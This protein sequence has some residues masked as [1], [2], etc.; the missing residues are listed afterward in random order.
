MTETNACAGVGA[1]S[2]FGWREFLERWSKE[3]AGAQDP[4]EDGRDG[5]E[6]AVRDRWLGFAPA[7][8]ERLA[9]C[10]ARL[11]H[12]LPPSYRSFLEVT[13]GWRHAG[14]FVY[15][16]ADTEQVHWHEDESGIGEM[17]REYLDEDAS[18][19]EIQEAAIWGRSLQLDVESDATSV[20]MDPEDVDEHGEWAVFTWAPWKA[21]PPERFASFWE[22]MQDAYREFH[23][24]SAGRDGE[25]AF[26]NATTE[27]LDAGVEEARQAALAGEYERATAAFAEAM[28]FGRPRATALRAQLEHLSGHY[29]SSSLRTL[30]SDPLYAPEVLPVIA[31]TYR[32]GPGDTAWIRHDVRPVLRPAAEEAA[33][34]AQARTFRYEPE[35]PFGAAVESAREQARWGEHDAAWRT[36][37]AALPQWRPLGPEHLA[38]MGLLADAL[39]GPV[40]T[41]ERGRAILAT[42]RGSGAAESAEAPRPVADQ[43]PGGLAWLAREEAHAHHGAY[44]FVL[45]EGVE[46]SGLPVLIGDDEGAALHEPMTRREARSKLRDSG[47]SSSYD[48]KALAAVG[49]AGPGWSF[50]YDGDPSPFYA[51]RFTSPAAAASRGG[52]AVVVW[53]EPDRPHASATLFHLSVAEHGEELYAFTVQGDD[54]DRSGRVPAALDPDRFFGPT[55]EQPG[56]AAALAAV[57]AEF[58]VSLPYDALAHGRLHTFT[59]RSWSRPPG[60]GETYTVIRFRQ[61]GT[62]PDPS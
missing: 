35:G 10:E 15:L 16:L 42:P 11:G 19:E 56:A 55:P 7:T 27:A 21:A 59:T 32:R 25:P 24:L 33:R 3:W 54:V 52:R 28:T 49:R 36:L 58:G 44:R 61:P 53:A 39:L 40:I 8:P 29:E 43:D 1:G 20:L 37:I 34:Q 22:F 48:D 62:D 14:G 30:A 9:A 47:E 41:P 6:A 23:S 60:P 17:F 13:D 51:P 2:G 18:P 57:S 12:R 31:A 5:D 26:A 46:P 38:P 50:A 45:V 4:D